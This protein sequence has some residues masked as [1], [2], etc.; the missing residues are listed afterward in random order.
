MSTSHKFYYGTFVLGLIGL[1]V[2]LYFLFNA[3]ERSGEEITAGRIIVCVA[4][5]VGVMAYALIMMIP[6][7]LS[8]GSNNQV[9][10]S[11]SCSNSREMDNLLNWMMNHH[12]IELGAKGN[13]TTV[14]ASTVMAPVQQAPIRALAPAFNPAVAPAPSSSVYP[15]I[16]HYPSSPPSNNHLQDNNSA[17]APSNYD[18]NQP[19][20]EQMMRN[21]QNQWSNNNINDDSNG[22]SSPSH[23]RTQSFAP[24]LSMNGGNGNNA[25][26]RRE[27]FDN[28]NQ[29]AMTSLNGVN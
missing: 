14:I 27:T 15:M 23:A 1:A 3:E 10:D 24:R 16:N 2:G 25:S 13:T 22:P 7:T 18:P 19:S 11:T 17:A 9:F 28:V 29:V 26:S 5:G 4:P 8:I 20:H 6:S 21:S 12:M